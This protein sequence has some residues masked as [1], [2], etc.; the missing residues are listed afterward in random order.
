[1]ERHET[2]VEIID[3]HDSSESVTFSPLRCPI[4]MLRVRSFESDVGTRVDT[5]REWLRQDGES[6]TQSGT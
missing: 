5:V 6:D 3:L 4:P 1:M 2:K